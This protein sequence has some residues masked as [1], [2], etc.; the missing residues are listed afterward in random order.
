MFSRII[1]QGQFVLN[2]GVKSSYDYDYASVSDTMNAAYCELL[3]RKL[4]SWQAKHGKFN[5]VAGIETEGIRIGYQLSRILGLPFQI[6]PHKRMDFAQLE[7]PAYP[8][9][10]HWLIVD[11]IVTTGYSFMRAVGYLDIEEKAETI[12]FACMIL[13]NPAN[14]DY[15]QV[16]GDLNKE[17]FQVPDERFEFIDKR[18]VSLYSEPA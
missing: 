11:D 18:I 5:V 8:A 4:A 6:I 15:S 17:Q 9:D 3:N 13:R 1:K 10:T 7:I 12:T 16:Q 2:S 14:L